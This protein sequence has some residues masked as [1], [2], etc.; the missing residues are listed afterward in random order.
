MAKLDFKLCSLNSDCLPL[1][2]TGISEVH[3]VENELLRSTSDSEKL[4]RMP[5]R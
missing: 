2:L 3:C 5:F 1:L 4:V